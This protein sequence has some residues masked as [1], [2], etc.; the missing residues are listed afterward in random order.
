MKNDTRKR[1]QSTIG[2]SW[3]YM[4]HCRQFNA[5]EQVDQKIII[6]TDSNPI[7]IDEDDLDMM[8]SGLILCDSTGQIVSYSKDYQPVTISSMTPNVKQALISAMLKS[9]EDVQNATTPDEIKQATSK[10]HSITSSVNS[11][12]NIAKLELDVIKTA[13]L[14]KKGAH[15]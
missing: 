13:R 8:L 7:T 15:K 4:G 3:E 9:I 11:V 14:I 1:L 12:T 2:K 5:W 10:A 6:A